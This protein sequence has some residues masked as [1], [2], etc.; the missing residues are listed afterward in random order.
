MPTLLLQ[1]IGVRS[2]STIPVDWYSE[3]EASQQSNCVHS[4]HLV[5]HPM[6]FSSQEGEYPLPPP[7]TL[8]SVL[9]Q[10]T[11]SGD[12]PRFAGGHLKETYGL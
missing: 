12:F 7:L 9:V 6:D 11:L 2:F 4:H 10:L 8:Q 1:E 5:A 3:E